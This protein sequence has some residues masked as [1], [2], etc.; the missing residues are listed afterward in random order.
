[1]ASFDLKL[2]G[3][4]VL[5]GCVIALLGVATG[6]VDCVGCGVP[7]GGA[8]P[9]ALSVSAETGACGL[10]TLAVSAFAVDPE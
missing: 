9:E 2:A 7:A 5:G 8:G 3:V 1:M 6:A 10:V 4:A